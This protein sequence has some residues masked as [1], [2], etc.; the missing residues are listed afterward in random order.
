ML[1]LKEVED[2]PRGPHGIPMDVAT[3]PAN[4]FRFKPPEAPSIDYAAKALD[5][6]QRAYYAKYDKKDAPISRAGH[7][8]SV[9]L[10][11]KPSGD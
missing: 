2:A 4:Q 11:D 7:L 10:M 8:W 1:A 3:D 6:G 5:E 9:H